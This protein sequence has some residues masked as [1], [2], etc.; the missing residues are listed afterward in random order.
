MVEHL[1]RHP[2]VEGLSPD[3]MANKSQKVL[4]SRLVSTKNEPL[5]N[6]VVSF[7]ANVESFCINITQQLTTVG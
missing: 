6:E 7:G 4:L 5:Q 1:P 3:K 2:K